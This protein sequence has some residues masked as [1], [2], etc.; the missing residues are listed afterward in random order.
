GVDSRAQA[1]LG[2]KL[3]QQPQSFVSDAILGIVEVESDR[4]D[5]KLFPTAAVL[6]E[7]L[8]KVQSLDLLIVLLQQTPGR[9]PAH[10]GLLLGGF[11]RACAPAEWSRHLASSPCAW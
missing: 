4:F 8:P 1:C 11:R 3:Q 10:G 9:Q 5:G 2:R 7:E 6:G